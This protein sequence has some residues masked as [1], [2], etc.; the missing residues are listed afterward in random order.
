MNATIATMGTV[1]T[2]P[3]APKGCPHDNAQGAPTL[4]L[5]L[6]QEPT[7][8]DLCSEH[9]KGSFFYGIYGDASSPD[10]CFRLV[11]DKNTGF[12][13]ATKMCQAGGKRFRDWMRLTSSKEMIEHYSSVSRAD[14]R[15]Y[16]TPSYE[17][18][19]GNRDSVDAQTSGTYVSKDL[20]LAIAMWI[21]IPFYQKCSEIV[22]NIFIRENA[23]MAPE[24]R[25]TMMKLLEEKEEKI[26]QQDSMLQDKDNKIGGLE[27]LI[28][29]MRLE[30]QE[31]DHAQ[32]ARD[33]AMNKKVDLLHDKMDETLQENSDLKEHTNVLEDRVIKVQKKLNI[34]VEDRAPQPDKTI[35]KERF[36]MMK[37]SDAEYPYY[38]V[39]GQTAYTASVIRAQKKDH[40]TVEIL[41]DFNHHPNSKTFYNRVKDQ[42]RSQGAEAL[43]NAIRI[44]NSDLTEQ[45]L[46][47]I[48]ED[49][50]E[51]KRTV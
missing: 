4:K 40:E 33:K 27:Q 3:D 45:D 20:I 10:T 19:V 15:G 9:I 44:E 24:E 1:Q 47:T 38:V 13:N 7:L 25:Q 12:F 43:G 31:R 34:A 39:R 16:H 2:V 36:V 8:K 11:I 30:Q 51:E 29:Q 17:V 49:V 21:S 28:Q 35:K 5:R 26:I 41:V 50:N 6:R 32:Q 14:L 37:R 18:V 42:L 22:N 23:S 46:I 48:L